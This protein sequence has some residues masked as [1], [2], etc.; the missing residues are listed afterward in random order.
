[1]QR[2]VIVLLLVLTV[3]GGS[4]LPRK[5]S[6][7]FVVTSTL[8]QVPV[9][10]HLAAGGTFHGRLTVQA[11]TVDESGQLVAA[12]VLT[13]KASLVPRTATKIP[14]RPFTAP[15]SVL[16][17]RGT[18][19]RVVLDLAPIFVAP[20]EQDITLVPIVLRSAGASKGE[21]LLQTS[22]CALARLQTDLDGARPPDAR[23][24]S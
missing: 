24:E 19:T 17:P 9:T 1:M 23:S 14:P 12:G 10:G 21:H 15:A 3:L 5:D 11:V 4:V 7:A 22:L 13:G 8:H 6:E 2:Y 20:L 16:D 18:C